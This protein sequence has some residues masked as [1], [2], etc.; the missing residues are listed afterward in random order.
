[1]C[2][3]WTRKK[4]TGQLLFILLEVPGHQPSCL[5]ALEIKIG[6]VL[7]ALQADDL[8]DFDEE[9]SIRGWYG[10]FVEQYGKR[11]LSGV[12]FFL[13]Q[14]IHFCKAWV[15]SPAMMGSTR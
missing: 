10:K 8:V 3:W 7:V 14:P 9:Q 15:S 11:R 1:M 2:E 13:A 4:P 5:I 12:Q 6:V